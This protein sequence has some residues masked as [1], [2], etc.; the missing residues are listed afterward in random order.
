MIVAKLQSIVTSLY[1]TYKTE[2]K[3]VYG[4]EEGP[5]YAGRSPDVTWIRSFFVCFV[6]TLTVEKASCKKPMGLCDCESTVY[7]N[8]P[9]GKIGTA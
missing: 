8:A 6:Q 4:H 1:K 7:C 3:N 9:G 5:S 2:L